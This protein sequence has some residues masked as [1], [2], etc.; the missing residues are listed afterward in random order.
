MNPFPSIDLWPLSCTES[1]KDPEKR[2][3]SV[4]FPALPQESVGLSFSTTS[5]T[6]AWICFCCSAFDTACSY[7]GTSWPKVC[8][9]CDSGRRGEGNTL[10]T[11]NC[12]NQEPRALRSTPQC[13]MQPQAMSTRSRGSSQAEAAMELASAQDMTPQVAACSLAVGPDD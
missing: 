5:A 10:S 2:A 11:Q 1:P 4:P 3:Q 12:R 6:G 13:R 7:L 9:A 8:L